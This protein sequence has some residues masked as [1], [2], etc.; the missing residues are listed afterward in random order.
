MPEV[1]CPI[2]GCEYKTP[3]VDATVVVELIKAHSAIHPG[4]AA[5]V[6][7]VERVRRPTVTAA[8]TTEDKIG[9]NFNNYVAGTKIE[10]PDK[11]IQLNECCDEPLRKD[12]TRTNHMMV[13]ASICKLAVREEDTMVARVSLHNMRQDRDE[14]VRGIGARLQGQANICK[15]ITKCTNCN[16]DVNYTE[17]IMRD[18]LSRGFC[19]PEIQMDLLGDQHQNMTLEEVYKFVE[20]KEAGKRSASRLFDSHAVEA[21]SSYRKSKQ[22]ANSN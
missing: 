15:F 18:V 5:A 11:V 4:A 20:A 3:D 16:E 8:G 19:D 1:P 14:T 12:M 10:G 21:S 2:P 7:K 13:M 6:A 9:P 17:A 22:Q